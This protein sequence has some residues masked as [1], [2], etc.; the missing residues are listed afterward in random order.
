MQPTGRAVMVGGEERWRWRRGWGPEGR[1]PSARDL[2]RGLDVQK[3]CV[4]LYCGHET[5]GAT[6]CGRPLRNNIKNDNTV[7]AEPH[8]VSRTKHY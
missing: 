3:G 1:S 4:N 8:V 5:V 7:R 2:C 6:P